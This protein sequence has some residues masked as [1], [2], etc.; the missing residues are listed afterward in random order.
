MGLG[1]RV[2]GHHRVIDRRGVDGGAAFCMSNAATTTEFFYGPH[3]LPGAV[4]SYVLLSSCFGVGGWGYPSRCRLGVRGERSGVRGWGKG[5]WGVAAE[6]PLYRT[7]AAT[8]TEFFTVAPS[9]VQCGRCVGVGVGGSKQTINLFCRERP[10]LLPKQWACNPRGGQHRGRHPKTRYQ[11]PNL[12]NC[13]TF[14][15]W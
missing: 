6:G 2:R 10:L 4:S 1:V 3:V 12:E 9:S 15:N 14:S 11:P 5:S 13:F 8:T 7:N